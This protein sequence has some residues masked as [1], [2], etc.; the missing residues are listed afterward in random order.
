M[1]ATER[2]RCLFCYVVRKKKRHKGGTLP[3]A[4]ALGPAWVWHGSCLKRSRAPSS[5]VLAWSFKCTRC[6]CCMFLF[7]LLLLTVLLLT[8]LLLLLTVLLLIVLL[9][10]LQRLVS[11]GVGG[12]RREVG[13][14]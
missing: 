6:L 14:R 9:F 13:G 8:L 11:D 10:L 7:T 2:R 3:T 12:R 5:S 4:P 1:K